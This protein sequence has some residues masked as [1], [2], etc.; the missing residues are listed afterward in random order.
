[1][2][3]IFNPPSSPYTLRS[4]GDPVLRRQAYDVGPD[5]DVRGLINGMKRVL[6]E[7]QGLG[8]AAQ[9]VGSTFRVALMRLTEGHTQ[10][11]LV[12]INPRIIA[13]SRDSD[14][15]VGEGCLSVQGGGYFFRTS[16]RRFRWVRLQYL[17]ESRHE[18]VTR[19]DGTNAVIAQHECDHLEGVCIVDGLSRQQ[20]RQAER[21]MAKGAR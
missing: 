19:F 8:L 4:I 17:D 13:H 11:V 21:I 14:L 3:G 2:S 15:S 5:D 12:T 7:E 20:R 18:C 6:A 10:G 1:M 9:Q 16:K